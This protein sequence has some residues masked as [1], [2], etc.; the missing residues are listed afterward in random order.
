MITIKGTVTENLNDSDIDIT[1]HPVEDMHYAEFQVPDGWNDGSHLVQQ[2]EIPTSRTGHCFTKFKV[3]DG[4]VQILCSGGHSKSSIVKPFFHPEDSFNI[5]KVPQMS[6]IK[7]EANDAFQR[8]FHA[9]C[10]N[11]QGEII[12]VGGKTLI[13]GQWSKIH[14]FSE[15][16][17]V[18]IN[19]D[20][21]YQVRA[22]TI[23]TDVEKLKLFTNFSFGSFDNKLFIFSG[24]KF[25]KYENQNLH[26][27]LPPNSSK[28]IL[29]EFGTNLYRIDMENWIISSCEGPADCGSYGGSLAVLSTSDII[30]NSDPHMYLY[31][32]RNLESPRCDLDE[33]FGSCSLQLTAKTRNTYTCPTP[34]C[35]KQIHVKCDKSI[36]GKFQAGKNRLC[37][38]CNNLDPESWKKIKVIRLQRRL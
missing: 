20:F 8:S 3:C 27:F 12:I 24:F 7:L 29:P 32:E 13:D 6:W 4:S 35:R 30:I 11:S 25:P 10:V 1:R 19:E 22:I 23:Q 28:D 17:I 5:L 18:N 21:S 15:V 36:R 9:Q 16:L 33:K 31:S 26:K 2:G 37:P 38:T 34:A 14:P